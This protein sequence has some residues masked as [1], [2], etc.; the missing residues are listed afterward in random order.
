LKPIMRVLHPAVEHGEVLGRRGEVAVELQRVERAAELGHV[1]VDDVPRDVSVLGDA[2]RLH[3]LGEVDVLDVRRGAER[4]R[5]RLD[6]DL[7]EVHGAAGDLDGRLRAADDVVRH[8]DLG[9]DRVGEAVLRDAHAARRDAPVH[10]GE[11]HPR[12]HAHLGVDADPALHFGELRDARRGGDR[13][14]EAHVAAEV[15]RRVSARREPESGVAHL[16]LDAALVV[17][18][19]LAGRRRARARIEVGGAAQLEAADGDLV[20]RDAHAR[21][22]GAE[23]VLV[24]GLSAALERAAARDV[25]LAGAQRDLER[26]AAF[27]VVLGLHVE[28]DLVRVHVHLVDGEIDVAVGHGHAVERQVERPLRLRFRQLDVQVLELAVGEDHAR[29][30]RLDVDLLDDELA[31]HQRE[32]ARVHRRAARGERRRPAVGRVDA[33]VAQLER[34]R[35][36]V[37]HDVEA[38]DDPLIVERLHRLLHRPVARPRRAHEPDGG[39][40]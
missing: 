31:A 19:E 16:E 27:G 33:H 24:D 9:V 22:E 39:E 21:V 40:R 23:R 37:R 1:D 38:R 25:A 29:A 17:R 5:E 11:L 35:P 30:R 18:R 8:R 2:E 7:R 14:A 6:V 36:E 3:E 20:G 34:Q 10:L 32:E 15:V 13:H 12:R 4:P 26:R 28:V